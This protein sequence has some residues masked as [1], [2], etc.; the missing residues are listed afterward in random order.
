VTVCCD[1]TPVPNWGNDQLVTCSSASVRCSAQLCGAHHADAVCAAVGAVLVAATVARVVL[2]V[3][4]SLLQWC[5]AV[6]FELVQILAGVLLR[7]TVA[8]RMRVEGLWLHAQVSSA[9][10]DIPLGFCKRRKACKYHGQLVQGDKY[11]G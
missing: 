9:L 1:A 7:V 4:A 2:T 5:V 10:L 3:L 11:V 8:G 6:R